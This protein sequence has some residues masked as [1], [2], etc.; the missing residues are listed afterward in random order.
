VGSEAPAPLAKTLPERDAGAAAPVGDPGPEPEREPLAERLRRFDESERNAGATSTELAPLRSQ[1][2]LRFMLDPGCHRLLAT[3]DDGG[4]PYALLLAQNDED[5]PERI[6]PDERGDARHELCT[7]RA[8]RLLVAVETPANAP[9][10]KLAVAH[11]GLPSGLP[12]RFGPD[13]ADR[14]LQALGGATAPR[15]LGAL[16]SATLG[17]QGRTPLPRTLLPQTCY[18]SAATSVHGAAQA[19]SIG[20]RV[21]ATNAEATASEGAPGPHLSFCTGQSG[22]VDLDVEAR[23]LGTAWMFFLFQMGPARPE[24]P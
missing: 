22:Q 13:V 9:E 11:F 16:V 19:L 15:R 20:A 17:A 21:G 5:T 10:R 3:G 1:G 12:T 2:Y 23:G 7:T 14:L 6:D 18:L 24:V 4:P 8:R